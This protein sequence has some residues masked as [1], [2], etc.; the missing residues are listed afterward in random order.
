[1]SAFLLTILRLITLELNLQNNI[2]ICFCFKVQTYPGLDRSKS[3]S[4]I[5]ISLGYYAWISVF[6]LE[7][8][9]IHR[10]ERRRL[11]Y[12]QNWEVRKQLLEMASWI[13]NTLFFK[14]DNHMLRN[15][16]SGFIYFHESGIKIVIKIKRKV[17]IEINFYVVRVWD[18]VFVWIDFL[19]KFDVCLAVLIYSKEL[20]LIYFK[21]KIAHANKNITIF[22]VKIEQLY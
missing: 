12:L 4:V 2:F 6:L 15:G 10:T 3:T 14:I 11:I 21:K 9:I 18:L 20:W 17:F 19:V 7:N 1:M 5:N 22:P 16:G 13:F 8:G